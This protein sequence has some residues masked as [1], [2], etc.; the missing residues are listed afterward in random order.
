MKSKIVDPAAER[1]K[2]FEKAELGESFS[3]GSG[4]TSASHTAATLELEEILILHPELRERVTADLKKLPPNDLEALQTY[5]ATLKE[6]LAQADQPKEAEA[7]AELE[8]VP[9]E[10]PPPKAESVEL[11]EDVV[12]EALVDKET[13]LRIMENKVIPD[14]QSPHAVHDGSKN[15]FVFMDLPSDYLFYDEKRAFARP[16]ITRDIRKLHPALTSGSTSVILDVI[17]A[18]MTINPRE[19]TQEDFYYIMFWLRNV[20]YP[21]TPITVTWRSRYGFTEKTTVSRTQFE[22]TRIETAKVRDLYAEMQANGL[23]WP[24][25][26]DVET[27]ENINFDVIE[28]GYQWLYERSRFLKP[29][30]NETIRQRMDRME[31]LTAAQLELIRE[32]K[33]V[34][35]HGVSELI[36]V[37]LD[38]KK[39]DPKQALETLE[40][41]IAS[42]IPLC[43]ETNDPD[44]NRILEDFRN[45][46]AEIREKLETGAE[47]LP[48]LEKA[49]AVVNISSFFPGI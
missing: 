5:L 13:A 16:L 45:E 4:K 37:K 20:S 41:N 14:A 9:N 29:L 34:M 19:L 6:E 1:I 12:E 43:N 15:Q 48:R 8:P 21:K 11:I 10:P 22:E 47:I 36:P 38:A 27:T 25:M 28:E 42:L 2:R 3:I 35:R 30:P 39:F 31:E 32:A 26:Y 17:A 44:L 33:E 23:D 40:K 46:A 24:R 7:E 49:P 18:V